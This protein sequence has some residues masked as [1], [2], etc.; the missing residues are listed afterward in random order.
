MRSEVFSPLLSSPL[1]SGKLEMVTWT[2]R[3]GAITP[4]NPGRVQDDEDR[5]RSKCE[6]QE[7]AAAYIIIIVRGRIAA[8]CA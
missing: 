5:Q 2:S 7:E 4:E 3:S 8:A 1:L 6:W